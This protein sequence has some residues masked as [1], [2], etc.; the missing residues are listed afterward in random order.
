[1]TPFLRSLRR[2]AAI[3]ANAFS[4]PACSA[5]VFRIVLERPDA[6]NTVNCRCATGSKTH[7]GSDVIARVSRRWPSG[8]KPDYG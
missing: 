1:M 5:P 4:A 6:L 8:R 2:L 7:N 3:V